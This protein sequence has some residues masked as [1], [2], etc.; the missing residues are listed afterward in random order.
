MNRINTVL[1]RAAAIALGVGLATAGAVLPSA[2]A[3]AAP[4]DLTCAA[5]VLNITFK[6]P[7]TIQNP[8]A[9]ADGSASLLGCVSLTGKPMKSATILGTGNATAS[10][11]SA[12]PSVAISGKATFTWDTGKTS[13]FT[14]DVNSSLTS[15]KFEA[16]IVKGELKNDSAVPTGPA[17]FVPNADFAV[18]GPNLTPCLKSFAVAASVINFA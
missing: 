6:T 11:A 18:C 10:F 17:V 3:Q 9:K 12:T 14:F 8:S 13:D 15:P 16:K 7:L 2:P 1:R 4:G 5:L